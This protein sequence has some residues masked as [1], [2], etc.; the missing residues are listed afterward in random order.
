MNMVK[1]FSRVKWNDTKIDLIEGCQ[2]KF[3]ATGI[4]VDLFIPCCADGYPD[5]LNRLMDNI[6]GRCKKRS[7]SAKWFQ[8]VG[9]VGKD[10]SHTIELGKEGTF[11]A[12]KNGRLFVY[13]NDISSAY[14]NNCGS[15]ELSVEPN[16]QRKTR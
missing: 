1:I 4:W 16:K 2:Y 11:F 14:W 6:F 8:L 9:E 5:A 10:K 3:K 12:R 13:A 7:P 15:V